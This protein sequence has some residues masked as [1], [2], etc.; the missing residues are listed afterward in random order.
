MTEASQRVLDVVRGRP[1]LSVRLVA[2][3]SGVDESTAN[4]HLRRLEKALCV[5]PQ[6]VGR[7]LCWFASD[8]GLCP[9]LRRAVPLLR[10]HE[11]R[12]LALALDETGLSAS[13]LVARTGVPVGTVRWLVP[14]LVG[15]G[16]AERTSSGR[17]RLRDGASTCV[18][19]A[20][21]G[22]RC[23][24]WGRCDVSIAWARERETVG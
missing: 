21:H 23:G 7:D 22:E 18:A 2:R 9:V 12:A 10:R 13:A 1:G 15:A 20:M 16:L 17:A 4:Y 6:P 5:A 24:A 19:K 14:A 8:C 3:A 11:A